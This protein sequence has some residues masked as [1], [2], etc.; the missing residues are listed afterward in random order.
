MLDGLYRVE[1]KYFVAG[2]VVKGGSIIQCA[3]ILR[4]NITY[5]KTI[6][7]LIEVDKNG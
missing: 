5:W 7:K 6:A 1:T 4:K 2:F 3:P